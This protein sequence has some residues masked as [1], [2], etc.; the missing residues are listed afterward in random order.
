ME[1]HQKETIQGTLLTLNEKKVD[2]SSKKMSHT[3]IETELVQDKADIAE[4]ES[5]IRILHD[6]V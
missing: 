4:K 2:F 1:E 6:Q 5:V 3:S